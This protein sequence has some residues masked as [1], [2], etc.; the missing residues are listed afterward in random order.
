MQ[1]DEERTK[2]IHVPDRLIKEQEEFLG[3]EGLM[4]KIINLVER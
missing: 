1:V 3:Y 2:A 4:F